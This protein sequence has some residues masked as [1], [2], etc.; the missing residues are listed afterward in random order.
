MKKLLAGLSAAA[1]ALTIEM[2]VTAVRGLQGL[3]CTQPVDIIS[4]VVPM[5]CTHHQLRIL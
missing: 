1:L 5:E 4:S 3:M 2:M